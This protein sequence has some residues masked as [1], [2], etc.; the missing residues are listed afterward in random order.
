MPGT[1]YVVATPI[2]NLEDITLRAMRVLREVNLICAEDTRVTRKLL[3]H[4]DIHTPLTSYHRHTRDSKEQELLERLVA[5]DNVAIV[6]DAGTPGVSDPGERLVAM[7]VERG[8][9]V[10]PVPGA[11]AA[12][13]ALVSSGLPTARFA[14]DGFP[15]RPKSDRKTFFGGLQAEMRTIVL[16][17]APTRILQT[18]EELRLALGERRVAVGREMTKAFEEVFRGTLSEAIDRFGSKPARGEMTIVVEGSPAS[19]EALPPSDN[20]VVTALAAAVARGCTSRD[21]V[22]EVSANLG[23]PR[24]LVYR[25]FLK[26]KEG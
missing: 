25:V 22:A 7:S 21:A 10:V 9:P 14:F 24:K 20:D 4:F 15:P 13:T 5:G 12:L 11:S 2:G 17:E 26:T 8:I 18:L 1:L 19:A 23:L 3:S 6:S 16:Y